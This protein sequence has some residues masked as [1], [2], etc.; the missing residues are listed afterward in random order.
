ML[1]AIRRFNSR[2]DLLRAQVPL[3]PPIL[4][5]AFMLALLFATFAPVVLGSLG[6]PVQAWELFT[7]QCCGPFCHQLA[8]RSFH[9]SAHAFPLCVRCTGMWLGITLGVASGV[10]LK[11]P[12]RWGVGISFCFLATA[13]SYWDHLRE[14]SG[15]PDWPWFRFAFGVVIFLSLCLA[16]SFDTLALLCAIAR[17]L[18]SVFHRAFAPN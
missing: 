9:L 13:A 8:S 2:F 10:F 15:Q 3:L 18:R 4:I 14:Q 6:L 1:S 7:F 16:V 12:K 5:A 11:L 17:K